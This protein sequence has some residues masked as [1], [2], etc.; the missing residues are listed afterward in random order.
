MTRLT[1]PA[2]HSGSAI[3]P[4]YVVMHYTAVGAAAGTVVFSAEDAETKAKLGEAVISG[5]VDDSLLITKGY[6]ATQG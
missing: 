2:A 4:R 3:V 1:A 5:Q 6:D